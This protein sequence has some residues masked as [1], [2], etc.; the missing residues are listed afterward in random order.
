M[1]HGYSADQLKVGRMSPV[2]QIDSD[3]LAFLGFFRMRPH[4]KPVHPK[5]GDHKLVMALRINGEMQITSVGAKAR[6]H[7]V[8]PIAVI[9]ATSSR[10]VF[11]AVKMSHIEFP[12]PRLGFGFRQYALGD[13]ARGLEI[14]HDLM[15]RHQVSLA[16]LIEAVLH[17]IGWQ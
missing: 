11:T 6:D 14:G 10:K 5:G 12:R 15:G 17:V 4:F 8:V 7:I 1:R 13:E 16:K 9:P 3:D 2:P